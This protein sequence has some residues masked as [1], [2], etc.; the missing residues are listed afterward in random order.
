VE[1]CVEL[2]DHELT[3][4]EFS[5]F[6]LNLQTRGGLLRAE[7]E[8]ET[9]PSGATHVRLRNPAV[10][11]EDELDSRA[12]IEELL[13]RYGFHERAAPAMRGDTA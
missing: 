5:D 12:R 10:V 11:F 9:T 1:S 2:A 8:T 7:Q 4:Q 13:H 6:E 3:S